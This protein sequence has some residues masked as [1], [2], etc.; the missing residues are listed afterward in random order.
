MVEVL[1]SVAGEP[2]VLASL[3][4][5]RSM[6]YDVALDDFVLTPEKKPLLDVASIIKVD[7]LQAFD[8]EAVALYRKRGLRLLAEKVEEFETF[9]SLK[10]KG[11][12]LF[13]G[14]FYARAETQHL[15]SSERN[16]NHAAL[17]QLL[18]QLQKKNTEFRKI[19]RII[20]QD[21]Q[22]TFLLLRYAN[23]AFFHYRGKIQTLFQALQVLGLKQVRNM[24]VTML[25]ANNGPASKLL[26][27]RALTRAGMCERLASAEAYDADS[28]FLAGL[29]SMMGVL[30]GKSLDILMAE[31]A[32]SQD[33]ID[34]ILLQKGHLGSLLKEVEAFENAR[35][36]GWPPQ[37]VEQLNRAWLK[38]QV[39]TTEILA[40]LEQ[41]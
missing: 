29:L 41:S 1:E 17:L 15:L 12:E 31:L 37:R 6:G 13:Q 10:A 30:L 5:I 19:E 35:M 38:S 39:W 28:A 20:A 9:E 34:A 11:F 33:I 21:A 3:K 18:A 27:S 16:N 25:L 36:R 7:M 4:E 8:E 2:E 22:L 24:V 14:Y 40:S 26:L 23:S 32:L